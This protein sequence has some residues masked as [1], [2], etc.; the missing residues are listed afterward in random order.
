MQTGRSIVERLEPGVAVFIHADTERGRLRRRGEVV[1]VGDHHFRMRCD[2]PIARHELEAGQRID[3]RLSSDAETLPLSTKFIRVSDD[4]PA[5]I[6]IILPAGGWRRNRRAYVR[7]AIAAAV[8]IYKG[9]GNVLSGVTENLSGGGALV[10]LDTC[11]ELQV[12]EDVRM[13]LTLTG[14]EDAFLSR[15]RVR[16]IA[17]AEHGTRIGVQFLDLGE[18]ERNRLCRMVLVKEFESRR[19]ELKALSA[20]SGSR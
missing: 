13:S 9:D 15:V 1:F 4:N 6:A 19:A 5:E 17:A 2:P 14:C 7:A 16:W 3:V 20:R 12:G 11:V 10:A 18:R 8:S